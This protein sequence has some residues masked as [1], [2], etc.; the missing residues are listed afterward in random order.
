MVVRDTIGVPKK[1]KKK[2][3]LR[4]EN[5]ID[6]VEDLGG[7]RHLLSLNIGAARKETNQVPQNYYEARGAEAAGTARAVLGQISRSFHYRDKKPFVK[8]FITYVR[9]HLEFCTPA[10]SP[11]TKSDIDCLEGVQKKMVGMVSGLS[12]KDYEGKLAVLG[13][14]SLQARRR[15][16]DIYTVHKIVHGV[17][18]LDSNVWFEKLA[19]NTITRAR[20]DP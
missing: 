10:W 2:M 8:L 18:D 17:G 5:T 14:E 20:A 3:Q 9:P 1:G 11:W 13:L 15:N 19:G 4:Y 6:I 7:Y 16:A 12:A